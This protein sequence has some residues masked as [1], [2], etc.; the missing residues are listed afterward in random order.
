VA[1]VVKE[2]LDQLAPTL[3]AVVVQGRKEVSELARGAVEEPAHLA[4]KAAILE[5]RRRPVAE[6]DGPV[7]DDAVR[8]RSPVEQDLFPVERRLAIVP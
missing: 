6:D 3:A 4:L 5:C 1:D 2:T 8:E 7:A